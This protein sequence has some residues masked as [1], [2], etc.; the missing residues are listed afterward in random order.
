MKMPLAIYA[1]WRKSC[2]NQIGKITKYTEL[3][4]IVLGNAAI[5]DLTKS[6][7]MKLRIDIERFNGGNGH[8]EYSTFIVGNSH[9]KYQLNVNGYNGSTAIS[10]FQYIL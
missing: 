3:F 7:K 4:G 9:T 6:G 8:A 5:H 1:F 2:F 10:R